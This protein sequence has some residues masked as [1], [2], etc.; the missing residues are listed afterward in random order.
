MLKFRIQSTPN[1]SARKYILSEEVKAEG[2]ISYR[3]PETCAHIP[4][5]H[6]LL[7]LSA[8]RQVHLFQNVVTITQDG[9]Q[10]WTELDSHVQTVICETFDH[11]DPHFIESLENETNEKS[12]PGR[13]RG[14]VAKQ[15]CVRV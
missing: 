4:L 1:P 3:E 12:L 11:H 6:A 2:K 15:C 13:G 10:A 7:S 5:V 9:A 14:R 8:V